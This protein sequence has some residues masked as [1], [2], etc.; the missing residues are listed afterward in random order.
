MTDLDELNHYCSTITDRS[1]VGIR[2]D[3]FVPCSEAPA[4][5]DKQSFLYDE[6]QSENESEK[7]SNVGYTDMQDRQNSTHDKS[8]LTQHK[9]VFLETLELFAYHNS[10]SSDEYVH[11]SV[12]HDGSATNTVTDVAKTV[13]SQQRMLAESH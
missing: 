7:Q 4:T 13:Y 8:K 10:L 6:T 9:R 5:I 11:L 1:A 3:D 12:A 2:E